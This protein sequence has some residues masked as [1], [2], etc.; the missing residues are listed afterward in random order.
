M[1]IP[2]IDLR[3]FLDNSAAVRQR[4]AQE[5]D[6]TCRESGF[7]LVTGHGVSQDLLRCAAGVTREFFAL[8]AAQKL[9]SIQPAH[10]VLRGY[11]PIGKESLS[12]SLDRA[13]PP[14][15]NESFMIGPPNAPADKYHRCPAAGGHFAPNVWP[16]RPRAFKAVWTRYYRAMED[17]SAALM[18]LFALSLDLPEDFFDDKIDRHIGRLRA[19]YYPPQGGR[20]RPGQLRA[21]AHTDYGSLTII[22]P[23]DGPGGL[24]VSPDG[25]RW[26]AVPLAPGGFVVNI[27]DLMER[28]TNERWSSTLHRVVNPPPGRPGDTGR[29]SLVFFHAPNYDTSVGSLDGDHAPKH[30]PVSAGEYLRGKFMKTQKTPA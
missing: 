10:G 16:N 9:K 6:R 27:G 30:A 13:A 28:W 7:L 1:K 11:F 2:T 8:P 18:R 22:L 20:P 3:R 25:R 17:L 26:S 24:E 23:E 4:V 29:L 21:G 5:V 14:D 15:L 19:R 12:Y